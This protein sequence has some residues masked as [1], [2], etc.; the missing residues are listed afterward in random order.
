MMIRKFLLEFGMECG[1]DVVRT[2]NVADKKMLMYDGEDYHEFD[3]NDDFFSF[4]REQGLEGEVGKLSL[5]AIGTDVAANGNA[6]EFLAFVKQTY[7]EWLVDDALEWDFSEVKNFFEKYSKG[8]RLKTIDK[9]KKCFVFDTKGCKSIEYITSGK[10]KFNKFDDSTLINIK[11]EENN[12]VN[13]Q[14][15]NLLNDDKKDIAPDVGLP[16]NDKKPKN[17]IPNVEPSPMKKRNED[18]C[19]GDDL[20]AFLQEYTK[21]HCHTTDYNIK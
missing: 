5:I 3:D 9:D 20:V 13:H 11:V 6:K 1:A 10:I 8:I 19:G 4:L 7:P 14:K 21:N 2:Y 16:K 18:S 12:Q 15:E 17:E